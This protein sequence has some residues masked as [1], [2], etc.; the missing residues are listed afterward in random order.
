M[1]QNINGPTNYWPIYW[2]IWAR[3]K[4]FKPNIIKWT[5]IKLQIREVQIVFK[6]LII[7]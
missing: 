2:Y 4:I 7:E 1:G 3:K 6:K 5:K